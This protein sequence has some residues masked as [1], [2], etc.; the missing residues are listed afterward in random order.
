MA[1]TRGKSSVD[2]EAA[3]AYYAS[4]PPRDRSYATVAAHFGVSTRT[5]E[6]HGRVEK[7]KE[8]LR[9]ITDQAAARTADALADARVEEITK[10]RRLIDASLIGYAERLR[11]GMRMTPADLERLNR[12]SLALID[13]TTHPHTHPTSDEH[14]MQERT[15]EHTAAV[16][17]ALEE[18]GALEAIGLTRIR[19]DSSDDNAAADHADPAEEQEHDDDDEATPAPEPPTLEEEP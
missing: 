18:I 3:F 9:A 10:I 19:P 17:D 1:E 12:L 15:P 13:E 7:W 16:L 5:V 4:L 2:W 8:R 11:G 14:D 6:T